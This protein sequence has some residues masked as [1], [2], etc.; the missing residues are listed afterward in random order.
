MD[1]LTVYFQNIRGIKSK[2]ADV[3]NEVLVN[4]YDVI[5]LCETWLNESVAS[6]ELFDSRYVVYRRDRSPEFMSKYNKSHGGGVLIAVK[7][8]LISNEKETW[9]SS[10][11][12]I[13]VSIQ[14]KYVNLNICTVYLPSYIPH[15]ELKKLLAIF[16]NIAQSSSDQTLII[17]DFNL[18]EIDWSNASSLGTTNGKILSLRE[19]INRTDLRQSNSIANSQSRILDL[20]LNNSQTSCSV[21]EAHA[22]SRRDSYHPPLEITLSYSKQSFLKENNGYR[23]R[24]Y[25]T[26]FL[27]CS[28]QLDQINWGS[29]ADLDC[30]D[31]LQ[32]FYNHLWEVIEKHTPLSRCNRSWPLWFSRS[33][34]K[35]LKEK[36]KF[37]GKFKRYGNPRDFDTF[38]ILRSRAKNEF[39]KCYKTYVKKTEENIKMDIKAFWRY[40]NSKKSARDLP[41][42]M[43]FNSETAKK[44]ND[45][46]NLFAKH[47]ASVYTTP[48][49]TFY[50]PNFPE[51]SNCISSIFLTIQDIKL[52]LK[53]L[54]VSKG[55]GPDG[56]PPIFIKNCGTVLVRPL[57]IIYNKS[58][59]SGRFPS[60]WKIA[61]I[62]PIYKSG[63]KTNVKN[64][65]PI[66]LLSCFAKVFESL[67]Y[68]H[69]YFHL[70]PVIS[71]KQ[72]GFVAGRSTTT[73]LMTYVHDLNDSFNNH[74]QVDSLYT[75][76][77]KAFDK[78]DHYILCRKAHHLGIHGVL[79][80]WITSYLCNRTQLVTVYGYDSVP[81]ESSSGIPQGSNLGPLLFIMFI[82][83]LIESLSCKCIAYA[84]D[85]KIYHEITSI[86]DTS[87]LQST[88]EQLHE[89]C[90]NNNMS[91][92]IEKCYIIT[93][94]K[95]K[96]PIHFLYKINDV[97]VNRQNVVKDLGVYLDSN[98]TY[99]FHYEHIVMKANK[100]AGFIARTVKPFRDSASV[101]TLYFCLIRSILEYNSVIWSPQYNIHIDRLEAIQRR[102]IR[103]LTTKLGM[104]RKLPTYEARLTFFRID[105][106]QSRRAIQDLSILY[107]IVNTKWDA[108]DLLSHVTLYTGGSKRTQ[109]LFSVPYCRNNVTFHDPLFRMCRAYNNISKDLDVFSQNL[110]SYLNIVKLNL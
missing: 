91:L 17:G 96:N 100:I 23:F 103:N 81:Y 58:L 43:H 38:S 71:N 94:T 1:K 20:V 68:K 42:Q 64:Y 104:K 61:K 30:D 75:D 16:E 101:L 77:A 11:E 88:L 87:I 89:W 76:F 41:S 5:C 21:A 67:I 14:F 44:G 66:S 55:A 7:R 99:R 33:L 35:I 108:M 48:S 72:H 50:Y 98:L 3:Y 84:D 57:Y 90:I 79:L 78:V 107:K 60:L 82:N 10:L 13:W 32:V 86:E 45:I 47:F 15:E 73:N 27:G 26:D 12:D 53:S 106:L 46:A 85:I 49:S 9:H 62:V 18:P 34:I 63:C 102:F 74:G 2:T 24:F 22:L 92:N 83:D 51:S 6:A 109:K 40:T 37:H 93:F 52:A 65:R 19:F 54:D 70:K 95:K 110:Y 69:I 39:D 80:R 28:T 25:K 29:Y 56:I 105:T 31:F 8:C 59:S 4:N 97:V 36:N